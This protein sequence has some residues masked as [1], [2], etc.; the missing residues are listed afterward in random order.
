MRPVAIVL[1]V[2]L[3]SFTMYGGGWKLPE[4]IQDVR[5]YYWIARIANS[6][7]L[8]MFV[9]ISGYLFAYQLFGLQK[10]S[11]FRIFLKSK[12]LRLIVP[13]IVFSILYSIL[14]LPKNVSVLHYIYYIVNGLGHMWFLPMLFWCFIV[15]Y[16]LYKIKLHESLKIIMLI[17]LSVFSFLPLPFQ[18]GR[19]CYYLL[20]FY[21]GKL[22]WTNRNKIIQKLSKIKFIVVGFIVFVVLFVSMTLF[23]EMLQKGENN[24]LIGKLMKLSIINLARIIYASVG[25]FMFYV[26]VNYL[27]YVRDLKVTER[28]VKFNGLCFGIYLYHQF[29]LQYFYYKTSLNYV[30]GNYWLPVFGF[31]VTLLLSILVSY[32]TQKS[33]W[34]RIL[35]G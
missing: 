3:H 1:L 12:L 32:F 10:K 15:T 23:V 14:F 25:L 8:E 30:L 27:L 26:F 2:L 13:S 7:M 5:A 11:S 35:I 22:I 9:F 4:H 33:K 18:F 28:I 20:F 21:S 34:G 29:F 24:T 31:I 6:F 19:T 17:V 16:F